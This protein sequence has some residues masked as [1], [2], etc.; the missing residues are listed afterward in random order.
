MDAGT[1]TAAPPTRAALHEAALRYLARYAAT[2]AGLRRV[3]E[4]RIRRWARVAAEGTTSDDV[5][6]RAAAAREAARQVVA[7]LVELGVVDDAAYAQTRAGRLRRE[8]QSR[9][10]AFADLRR[11][12]VPTETARAALPGDPELELGAALALARRRRIGPFRS[13]PADR[14]AR[15]RERGVLA[16]A[17]FGEATARQALGMTMDEAE[18]RLARLRGI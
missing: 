16:R 7:R 15:L 10:A 17:G 11:R 18:A 13:A 6:D 5:A 9:R 1:G 8:G 4:R 3:L 14:E 2:E 12:G